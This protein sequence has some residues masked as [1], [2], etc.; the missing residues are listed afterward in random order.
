MV[1][2]IVVVGCG[3]E[4]HYQRLYASMTINRPLGGR[5]MSIQGWGSRKKNLGG[6]FLLT[7][8]AHVRKIP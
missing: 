8:L 6:V 4:F 1:M 7:R 5:I 3:R 2:V